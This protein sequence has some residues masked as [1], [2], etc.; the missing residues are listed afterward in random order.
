MRKGQKRRREET[1]TFG[2]SIR[3]IDKHFPA[4]VSDLI[5]EY[6][7]AN[8][9]YTL[10]NDLLKRS[11]ENSLFG[12]ESAFDSDIILREEPWLHLDYYRAHGLEL[13]ESDT[14]HLNICLSLLENNVYDKKEIQ[15]I[16]STPW[17]NDDPPYYFS[18][19]SAI[20]KDQPYRKEDVQEFICGL[21]EK[22]VEKIPLVD[23]VDVQYVRIHLAM[24][25]RDSGPG[26]YDSGAAY[27]ANGH[28]V[29]NTDSKCALIERS[30]IFEL[31]EGKCVY[32]DFSHAIGMIL[33]NAEIYTTNSDVYPS[34][35]AKREAL[36][37]QIDP[38]SARLERN[39]LHLSI[40]P[41]RTLPTMDTSE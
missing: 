8:V 34:E 5:E 40:A 14:K 35:Q 33:H 9:N 24:V 17:E 7:D 2:S 11:N 28:K 30:R 26:D 18:L 31:K 37:W 3:L 25:E 27:E 29:H 32:S 36:S 20:L 23:D 19:Y 6:T 38:A 15:K 4:G 39:I 12:R 13:D 10:L 21:I 1:E 41:R 22:K 16:L